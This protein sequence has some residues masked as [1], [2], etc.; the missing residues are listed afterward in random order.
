MKFNFKENKSVS[1][2]GAHS[3]RELSHGKESK[4]ITF[5]S[6]LRRIR[7][8]LKYGLLL[9]AIFGFIWIVSVLFQPSVEKELG[10]EVR[11]ASFLTKVLF[12][13]D[14]ALDQT[15]LAKV[16][17]LNRRVQLMDINIFDLKSKLEAFD[18]VSNAEVNRIFP[19]S[20]KI[21]LM[22]EQPI[23]KIRSG[24]KAGGS[25]WS[26]LSKNGIIFFGQG[27][28]EGFTASLPDFVPYLR[29]G[30]RV[31]PV[32]GVDRVASLINAFSNAD[33]ASDLEIRAVSAKNFSGEIGMPGQVIEIQ[34]RR[35]P[36][37]LFSA[38]EDFTEQIKRLRYIL[39]HLSARG[40]PEVLKVDLSL[41]RSAAV[42]FKDSRFDAF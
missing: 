5:A 26:L 25:Q 13:T 3:W 36:R 6:V 4:I 33:L 24:N 31:E 39:I 17:N 28:S 19:D 37:I 12:Q 21:E 35:I 38:Y 32:L 10:T 7:G 30:G 9:T 42:Q 20:L 29:E 34:T 40:D 8:Y 2:Q 27:Y 11:G 14:G 18:Q 41:M 1:Y 16:T 15:W 22:E 23:C